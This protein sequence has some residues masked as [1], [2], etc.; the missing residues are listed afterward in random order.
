MKKGILAL[1]VLA[2]L[3]LGI[4]GLNG[5]FSK[6]DY[7]DLINCDIQNQSCDQVL[8]GHRVVLDISPKP[9]KAMADLNFRLEFEDLNLT[10]SPYIDLGMPGMDMG[11]N[12]VTMESAGNNVYEGKGVIVRCKSGRTEWQANVTIPGHG[13][14]RYVF[15]VVY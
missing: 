15:D 8:S 3:I 1:V 10:D 11:P 4:A 9:V 13:T 2:V 6:K 12:K 7:K 14:L 5:V